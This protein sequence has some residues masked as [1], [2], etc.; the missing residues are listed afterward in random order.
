MIKIEDLKFLTIGQ[1]GENDL[2]FE[3]DMNSWLNELAA[4]GLDN[5]NI[6]CHIL[7]K[8]F[9]ADEPA[10]VVS[11]TWDRT[12]GILTWTIT[13]VVTA[14]EGQGYMEVRALE[15][16]VGE[17]ENYTG[18]IKKS[19]VIP[20]VVNHSI[21]GIST[22]TIPLAQRDWVNYILTVR[23]QLQTMF[24]GAATT[25]AYGT[26]PT[27][28][29]TTGW[30][31]DISDLMQHATE[32]LW[33]RI[34]FTWATGATSTIEFPV[35]IPGVEGNAV[36]SVNG[37]LGNVVL[38]GSNLLCITESGGSAKTINNA[39]I[40]L[41]KL[42][43]RYADITLQ[44]TEPQ[45]AQ[46]VG[47]Q[48]QDILGNHVFFGY[49]MYRRRLRGSDPDIHKQNFISA[50]VVSVN[51]A[52]GSDT[53]GL[54]FGTPIVEPKDYTDGESPVTDLTTIT[55]PFSDVTMV[56][57]PRT[58]PSTITVRVAYNDMP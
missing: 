4:D 44:L 50:T 8:P 45:G 53:Y 51:G 42:R 18:L 11:T 7:Y 34:T 54:V 46:T 26:D 41:N 36:L 48:I 47:Y 2:V 39:L 13:S 30:K 17:P 43:I 56:D 3:I 25:Y 29:P 21:S 32:F 10:P 12:T 19:R 22:S 57:G 28:V 15:Y 55:V 23:S 58:Y 1:Q 20:T 16:Y 24:E 6:D 27:T 40:P 9:G 38:D 31:T 35:Y 14:I 5:D 52:V 33:T 37:L 49:G